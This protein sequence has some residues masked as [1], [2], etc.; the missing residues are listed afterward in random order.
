MFYHFETVT[1]SHFLFARNFIYLYIYVIII[2]VQNV[3]E[4][5]IL[6]SINYFCT[7]ILFSVYNITDNFSVDRKLTE[8]MV[9]T[10]FEGIFSDI[11]IYI[12]NRL[13]WIHNYYLIYVNE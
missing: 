7:A 5:F 11:Y 4:S 12:P 2:N 6:C 10:T 1:F 8:V 3:F 13:K 9:I